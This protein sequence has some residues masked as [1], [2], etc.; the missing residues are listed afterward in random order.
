MGTLRCSY[1]RLPCHTHSHRVSDTKMLRFLC[2]WVGL[3]IVYSYM[4]FE[5]DH[6]LEQAE[7]R[8]NVQG[9]LQS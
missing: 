4:A 9:V 6:H 2:T 7:V 3:E 1:L 8:H 5:T